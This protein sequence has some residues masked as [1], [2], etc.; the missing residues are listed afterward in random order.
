MEPPCVAMGGVSLEN[1]EQLCNA[2]A[3]FLALRQ[4][5]WN[6]PDGPAK[7]IKA[8]ASIVDNL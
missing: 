3:D 7:A 8:F 1:A 6:H 4:A 5:V 2:G